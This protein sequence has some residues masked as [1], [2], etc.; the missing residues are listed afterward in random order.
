MTSETGR[1]GS[2]RKAAGQVASAMTRSDF[3][4]A[5]RRMTVAQ[6]SNVAGPPIGAKPVERRGVD[7]SRRPI[8]NLARL[9]SGNAAQGTECLRVLRARAAP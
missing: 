3:V 5:A 1:T 8:Q 2:Q 7:F 9:A 4:S 6:F